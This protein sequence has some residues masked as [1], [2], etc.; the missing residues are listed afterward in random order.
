MA[1]KNQVRESEHGELS[2]LSLENEM[3]FNVGERSSLL[4]FLI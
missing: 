2:V 3:F 4:I 1:F